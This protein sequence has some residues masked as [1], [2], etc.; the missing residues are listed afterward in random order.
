MKYTLFIPVSIKSGIFFPSTLPIGG[1]IS[2]FRRN[3]N[4]IASSQSGLSFLV[5]Q[6]LM[7]PLWVAL[8]FIW[9]IS[10]LYTTFSVPS[11]PSIVS[12][13][14][15]LS[16]WASLL[17]PFSSPTIE[18]PKWAGCDIPSFADLGIVVI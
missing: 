12:K 2:L 3:C 10:L 17:G 9:L 18:S 1:T 6:A 11:S 5:N 15:P 8:T 4:G 16:S 14:T 13:I 7:Y